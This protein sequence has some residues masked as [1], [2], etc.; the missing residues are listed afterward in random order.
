VT[1]EPITPIDEAAQESAALGGEAATPV[2]IG[3]VSLFMA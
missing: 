1:F 3:R 2:K